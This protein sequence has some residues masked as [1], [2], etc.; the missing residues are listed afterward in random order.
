MRFLRLVP[1]FLAALILFILVSVLWYTARTIPVTFTDEITVNNRGTATQAGNLV[2]QALGDK[3]GQELRIPLITPASV[4]DDIT[5]EVTITFE[6]EV[7]ANAQVKIFSI[8]GTENATTIW[9]DEKTLKVS[10]IGYVPESH[11]ALVLTS[12]DRPFSLPPGIYLWSVL[13]H[14]S[15]VFWIGGSLLALLIAFF[16]AMR[17]KTTIHWGGGE[18]SMEIPGHLTP[19]EVAILHHGTLRPIDIVG[20]LYNL[21]QRG[22]VQILEHPDSVLF[23]RTSKTEGLVNYERNMLLILFPEAGRVA[24]LETI[25]ETLN[26]D[27][28][29]AV[30][31]QLYVEVYDRFTQKGYLTENPRY[32]HLWY[33]TAGIITQF[34]GLLIAVLSYLFLSRDVP[35]LPVVGLATYGIGFILYH[36]GYH[37]V[38]L[39]ESG[40][41]VINDVRKLKAYLELPKQIGPE[42]TMGS[43]F[44]LLTPYA[45]SLDSFQ[46]WKQRFLETRWYVPEWYDAGDGVVFNADS[47]LEHMFRSAEAISHSVVS[48]K[49]PNVD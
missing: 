2:A 28:F 20:V 35:A 45:L 26:H 19:L 37:I 38:P 29:S 21:A 42:D 3:N 5:A 31:S 6:K 4:T 7:Q 43:Q 18:P 36:L 40:K 32:I 44:Y 8:Q 41:A 1:V 47:L 46:F 10:L 30:V 33:K 17:R 34:A 15:T 16:V 12:A 13:R 11:T 14:F 24:H 25:L 27:L 23:L 48:L 49:D 39:T 9:T 22:Y